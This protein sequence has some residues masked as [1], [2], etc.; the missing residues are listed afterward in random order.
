[1]RTADMNLRSSKLMATRLSGL[2]LLLAVASAGA[3]TPDPASAHSSH[4]ASDAPTT[5]TNAPVASMDTAQMQQEL[6][7]L[8]DQMRQLEQRV[9]SSAP[10]AKRQGGMNSMKAP[11]QPSMAQPAKPAMQMSRM[12]MMDDDM[13]MPMNDMKPSAPMSSGGGMGME[14][15][16]MKKM[17]RTRP[18]MSDNGTMGMAAMGGMNSPAAMATP[19][20]LPGF[21]GQS[22]L[23]HIGATGFFLDHP[24][25]IALTTQQQQTLAQR[26]QQSL[27]KQGELQRQVDAAEQELWQLTGADQPQIGDIE[28]K[29]REIE[30]LRGDQRL[31][32]IRAVGESA[33]TL[34]DEQRK[35][36]TGMA[37]AQSTADQAPMSMPDSNTPKSDKMDH[38]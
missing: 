9:Q 15:D 22:H 34:T 6:S 5:S 18:K 32:F 23:Y 17:E 37:P 30:R 2:M 27:L 26:K 31:A 1:M 13:D 24:E 28:K 19:S 25:H 35:Q 21:P 3:Q 16:M 20:A 8:R 11:N 36:L 29:V 14:M 12:G 10:S 38:M 33:K 4:A 7:K